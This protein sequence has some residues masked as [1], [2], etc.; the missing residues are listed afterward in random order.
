MPKYK[1]NNEEV[2]DGVNLL[3]SILVRYPEIGTISFDPQNN[4]LKLTFM[5][6]TIPSQLD[7]SNAKQLLKSSIIAYTTL[8][9]LPL[10]TVDIQ[11]DIFEKVAMLSIFRD[12]HTISKN[13]IALLIALLRKTFKDLIIDY[14]DSLLE[15]DLLLQ[16]EVIEDMLTNLKTHYDENRLIGIREDGRVLV[17]N[18]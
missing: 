11:L 13:E 18:K 9:G 4:W 7:F 8:E 12:V 2:S 3:I 1:E 6:S 14:N 15:E 10:K 5:L 16:E 17:F